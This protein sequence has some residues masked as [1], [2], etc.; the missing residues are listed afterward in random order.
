M[1]VYALVSSLEPNH[2]RYIGMTSQALET[3]LGQHLTDTNTNSAKAAWI[4][5]VFKAG[6][7]VNIVPLSSHST[8]GEAQAAEAYL[9]HFFNGRRG[10]VNRASALVPTIGKPKSNGRTYDQVKVNADL[11][12]LLVIKQ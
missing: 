8:A 12:K 4:E 5:E 2:I 3:R 6:A 11:F 9:I 7:H 10:L 1:Q